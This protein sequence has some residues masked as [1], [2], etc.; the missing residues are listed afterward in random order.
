M[1]ESSGIDWMSKALARNSE[2]RKARFMEAQQTGAT[3][4]VECRDLYD[5]LD[6]DAGVYFK[7]CYTESDVNKMV[8]RM[9]GTTPDRILGIYSLARPVELLGP[10]LTREDWLTGHR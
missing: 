5:S 3:W 2:R 10:G 4:L 6:G 7:A 1:A 9:D 8:A